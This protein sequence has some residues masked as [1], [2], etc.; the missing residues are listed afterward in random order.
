MA[1]DCETRITIHSSKVSDTQLHN[2]VWDGFTHENKRWEC[3]FR[4]EEYREMNDSS[5]TYGITRWGLHPDYAEALY[6]HLK[7]QDK[8]IIMFVEQSETGVDFCLTTDQEV[9]SS[10]LSGCATLNM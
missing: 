6:D 3:P 5:T 8:E 10:T 1:N 9:G 2:L 4:Y 7:E